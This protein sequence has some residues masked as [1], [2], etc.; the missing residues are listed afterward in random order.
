[1]N[2]QLAKKYADETLRIRELLH[3]EFARQ[4]NA[5]SFKNDSTIQQCGSYVSAEIWVNNGVGTACISNE[6]LANEKARY[7]FKV[8]ALEGTTAPLR[9][10]VDNCH[11]EA[12]LDIP[13]VSNGKVAIPLKDPM[14]IGNVG[15]VA[16]GCTLKDGELGDNLYNYFKNI[17]TR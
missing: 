13:T 5:A 10:G 11:R 14:N 2:D 4:V 12:H 16:F 6:D 15:S 1:M 8:R 17:N 7:L 3:Q 9:I